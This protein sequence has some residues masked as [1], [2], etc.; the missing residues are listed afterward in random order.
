MVKDRL[1]EL[2]AK[3]LEAE[4][5]KGKYSKVSTMADPLSSSLSK[6]SDFDEKVSK[7]REDVNQMN[8][9]QKNLTTRPQFDDN[10]VKKEVREMEKL[11]DQIFSTATKLQKEINEFRKNVS[12]AGL[13]LTQEK[14]LNMHA[15]R[16]SSDVTK[17][18][19]D[20]RQA[21]VDYINSTKKLHHKATIAIGNDESAG[22]SESNVELDF[23][24]GFLK[25]AMQAKLELNEIKARDEE[26]KKLETS[27]I[28]VNT[29]FKEINALI[30]SQGETLDTIEKQVNDAEVIV[31]SGKKQLNEAKKKKKKWFK[32]RCCLIIVCVVIVLIVGGIIALVIA[33]G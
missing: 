14:M 32:R 28:E 10:E 25:E 26:I 29:L 13:S 18:L 19:N 24:A 30:M 21:Q 17:V 8:K 31:E 16:L 3:S 23:G 2:Q 12:E 6:V 20:F 33:T 22:V 15:T 9:T 5:D 1:E 7:L 11:S 27:V 4:K